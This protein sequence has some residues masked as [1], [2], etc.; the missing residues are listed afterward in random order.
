MSAATGGRVEALFD[1]AATEGTQLNLT[2]GAFYTIVDTTAGE[3]WKLKKMGTGG[4][5]DYA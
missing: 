5:S 4:R 1:F 3:W 2:E